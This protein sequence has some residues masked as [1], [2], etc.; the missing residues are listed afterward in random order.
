MA[1]LQFTQLAMSL[2]RH[3]QYLLREKGHGSST[4]LATLETV[5]KIP[6]EPYAVTNTIDDELVSVLL[7]PLLTEGADELLG[8]A[9][10]EATALITRISEG[11]SGVDGVWDGCR[12]GGIWLWWKSGVWVVGCC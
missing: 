10:V 5:T 11:L 1:K 6:K 7:D 4:T 9:V 3:V 12:T 8:R 2:V